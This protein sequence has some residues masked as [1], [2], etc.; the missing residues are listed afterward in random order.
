MRMTWTHSKGWTNN[1]HSIMALDFEINNRLR[2]SKPIDL[3][4]NERSTRED[5]RR[6]RHLVPSVRG[7]GPKKLADIDAWLGE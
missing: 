7:I 6:V 2:Y 5:V 1:P 3:R 4:L